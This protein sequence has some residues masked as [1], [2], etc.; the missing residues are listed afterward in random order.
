ML[1]AGDAQDERMALLF[2][3]RL[4]IVVRT[5]GDRTISPLN[6]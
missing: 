5:D 4:M 1:R 6:L 2:K 3:G